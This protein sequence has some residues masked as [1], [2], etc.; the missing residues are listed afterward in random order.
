MKAWK[1]KWPPI[2]CLQISTHWMDW[3]GSHRR[4]WRK[5]VDKLYETLKKSDDG[6]LEEITEHLVQCRRVRWSNRC[7]CR[8]ENE[9]DEETKDVNLEKSEI[10]DDNR[11]RCYFSDWWSINFY[12]L[13]HNLNLNKWS[14]SEHV[15]VFLPSRFISRRWFPSKCHKYS[16]VH[17]IQRIDDSI[18]YH[19]L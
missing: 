16:M 14:V 9:K 17:T 18:L 19:R 6:L 4:W 5:N 3:S 11:N 7:R 8:A 13:F 12:K 15:S 10:P 2:W 1:S